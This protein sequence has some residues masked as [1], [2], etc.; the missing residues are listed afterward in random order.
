MKAI[1]NEKETLIYLNGPEESER[2]LKVAKGLAIIFVVFDMV[3]I[4]IDSFTSFFVV[5]EILVLL[6][7]G[8][9]YLVTK[10]GSKIPY[11]ILK[12]GI[13][14]HKVNKQEIAFQ[15]IIQLEVPRRGSTLVVTY[16][17]GAS[18]EKVIICFDTELKEL[19]IVA[20]A[21]KEYALENGFKKIRYVNC[22]KV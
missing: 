21:I 3:Q 6:A 15:D 22:L 8:A 18:R 9:M 14:K 11:I 1:K 2:Y 13:L 20:E 16:F 4:I 5:A 10:Q 19:Q 7:L 17:Q 12:D